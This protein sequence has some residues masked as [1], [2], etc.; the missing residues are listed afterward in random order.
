MGRHGPGD[1]G[2]LLP[3]GLF[4]HLVQPR[5][6]FFIA[7]HLLQGLLQFCFLL[8]S[9]LLLAPQQLVL[10]LQILSKVAVTP[11]PT[12][13]CSSVITVG[14]V[15][16]L[17]PLGQPALLALLALWGEMLLEVFMVDGSEEN[18][19]YQNYI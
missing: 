17:A 16:S 8:K 13:A 18:L 3:L 2:S 19:C 9:F 7:Q 10:E 15:A 1:Y 12:T 5:L 4:Q 14:A 11:G 6:Q